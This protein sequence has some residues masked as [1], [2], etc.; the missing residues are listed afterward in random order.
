MSTDIEQEFD[1]FANEPEAKKSGGGLTAFLAVVALLLALAV[2]GWN[3]WQWWLERGQGDELAAQEQA[4]AAGREARAALDSRMN[5]LERRLQALDQAGFGSDLEELETRIGEVSSVEGAHRR[6]IEALEAAQEESLARLAGVEGG[7]SALV[8]RGESP[9]RRLEM[10]EVD[11]LLRSANERAQLYGDIE[12]AGRAL[13]LADEQLRAMDDPLYLPVRRE[14][15]AALGDLEELPD[16]D[17]VRLTEALAREQGRI[18]SLPVLGG[19]VGESGTRSE[20]EA[21]PEDASL[22]QRFKAAMAGLVTVRRRASDDS[23][24]TIGDR[25]YVRQGLWL[26]L[27]TARLALL[28]RDPAMYRAALERA[29]AALDSWFD[30]DDPA[31]IRS[32]ANLQALADESLSVD[33]PPDLSGPW[34]QLQSLRSVRAPETDIEADMGTDTGASMGTEARPESG[35]GPTLEPPPA[36]APDAA[37]EVDAAGAAE[38]APAGETEGA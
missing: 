34:T 20:P 17:P 29:L 23:L 7:L 21:L 10:E 15:A 9:S 3:G 32:R 2:A 24:I 5:Q 16:F 38:D 4:L 36:S 1:P 19:Q 13:A 18:G 11:Y 25:E 28:R 8:V 27:E 14:I 31:V 37:P 6:R 26:Q 12:T 22:W 30:G 33:S 35:T